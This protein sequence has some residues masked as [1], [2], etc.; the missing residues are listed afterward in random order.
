VGGPAAPY[1]QSERTGL[2]KKYVD[3]LVARGLAYPCFCTGGSMW[4]GERGWGWVGLMCCWW[5]D[6]S[7]VLHVN[8]CSSHASATSSHDRFPNR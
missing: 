5:L 3:D 2:Y 7:G 1:R 6:S 4:V 8:Q